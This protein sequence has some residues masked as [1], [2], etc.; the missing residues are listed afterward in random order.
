MARDALSGVDVEGVTTMQAG[1]ERVTGSAFD[2][3]LLDPVLGD[4]EDG[5][6]ALLHRMRTVAPDTVVVIW[7]DRPTVEFAV[8][9]MRAG[10]LD[11]LDKHADAAT[12]RTIV[13]RAIQHGALAREVRRLRGE[14]ERARGLG[15]VIGE[16]ALMRQLLAMIERVAASDATV[17]IVGESGTG[18]E[19]LARTIH[20]VGPRAEGPFIAFDCSALAPS[21]I[22]AELF[23]HEKGAF[24]GANRARR[25]LFREANA[26][27]IFLDEIGDIDASVQNKLLRVLQE[28]EIKPVGGDRPVQIDVRVVAATNKD[29]KQLVARGQ[30]R[31]DLYWRLAVVP[32]QVPPLRERKEDIPLLAAHILAK[33]R[34]AAKSF[35]GNEAPYPTQMTAKA[36]QRLQSYRW[37]GNIRELENVLSRAAILCDGETIRSHD[38]AMLGLDAGSPQ[39][40]GNEDDRVELPAIDLARLGDGEGLKDVTDRALRAVERAAIALALKSDRNPAAAAKRLGISR[41]S[42]YTKM[43]TYGLDATGA[44]ES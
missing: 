28:R 22:E 36:L 4:D 2:L 43:K 42:I 39:A 44:D 33:R 41:A 8:R 7:S 14:V 9:A 3:V 25:G 27:T 34:G 20:R 18:K 19:L 16:S 15:E 24:T 11:V 37:P 5:A 35:A 12:I 17:L 32:I 30:F 26:G 10:A 29:L 1:L 38:L 31:E 23:G 6:L 40:S 21:L 13:E